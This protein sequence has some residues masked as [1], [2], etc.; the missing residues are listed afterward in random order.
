MMCKITHHFI[1]SLQSHTTN[2]T[3]MCIIT[4]YFLTGGRPAFGLL[5]RISSAI[6]N[7]SSFEMWSSATN[8]ARKI[9]TLLRVSFCCKPSERSKSSFVNDKLTRVTTAPDWGLCAAVL[10]NSRNVVSLAR[11]LVA[12]FWGNLAIVSYAYHLVCNNTHHSST[13][14]LFL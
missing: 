13:V 2:N 14:S 9:S 4:H 8:P 10:T 6:F 3:I 7:C 12:I 1:S 5:L 11:S